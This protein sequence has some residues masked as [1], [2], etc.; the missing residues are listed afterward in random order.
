MMKMTVEFPSPRFAIGTTFKRRGVVKMYD[1]I[2][3]V[4]DV[5]FTFDTS[6][7]YVKTRYVATH[8]KMGQTITERDI[9]ETT[10]ARN[11]IQAA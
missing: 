8:E 4:T 3:T 9:V 11:L 10:I 1:S 7:K 5:Q 6:G 2:G